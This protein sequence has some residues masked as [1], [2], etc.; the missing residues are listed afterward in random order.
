MIPPWHK[1]KYPLSE[2]KKGYG[3]INY[4]ATW[5]LIENLL[6]ASTNEGLDS[7]VHIPVKKEPQ[8]IKESLQVP[9]GWGLSALVVLGYPVKDPLLPV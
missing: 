4:G 1:Q 9:D 6:L 2:D 8:Q 3:L 5:A 7:M